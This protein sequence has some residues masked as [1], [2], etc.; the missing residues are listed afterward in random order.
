M[1]ISKICSIGN[2]SDVNET[3]LLEYL[4]DDPLTGVIGLYAE[5]IV[6]VRRL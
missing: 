6:D 3:D 5:S 4:I 1:G 2:K